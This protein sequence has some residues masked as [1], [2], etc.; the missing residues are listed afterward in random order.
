MPM[1]SYS[2]DEYLFHAGD[3]TDCLFVV[4]MGT[5]KVSYLTLNGQE[6]ILNVFQA[7]DIFGDLFLGKYRSR[8]GTA[9]ALEELVVCRLNESDFLS[10]ISKFPQVS[11][12]FIQH[13]A[14]QQRETI[15]RMQGIVY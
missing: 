3:D 6:K 7:G 4:Q 12:N 8:I 9:Q 13:Q 5:V 1:E 15:A 10:L 2:V 14:N 11:F